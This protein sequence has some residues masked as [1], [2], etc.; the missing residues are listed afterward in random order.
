MRSQQS[1]F[2]LGLSIF[3]QETA[4]PALKTFLYY[5][6]IVIFFLILLGFISVMGVLGVLMLVGHL[7][8]WD[9]N[10]YLGSHQL[11]LQSIGNAT[12]VLTISVPL[13]F[14]FFKFVKHINTLGLQRLNH[15]ENVR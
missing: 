5:A 8:K 9:F 2:L 7:V 13:I 1:V 3:W 12:I 4:K 10:W 11:A 15:M 6:K 14:G